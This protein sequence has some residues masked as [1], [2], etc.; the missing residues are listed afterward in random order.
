MQQQMYDY[1]TALISIFW[2]L[3]PI[4][5]PFVLLRMIVRF[6]R[7]ANASARGENLE[8]MNSDYNQEYER[9]QRLRYASRERN[10]YQGQNRRH[11]W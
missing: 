11:R 1:V 8:D 2:F 6:I 5:G 4:V 10:G 3:A 9:L 7:W